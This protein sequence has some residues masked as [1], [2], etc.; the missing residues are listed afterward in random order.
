MLLLYVY[1]VNI[2]KASLRL[3]H[4]SLNCGKDKESSVPPGSQLRP[5]CRTRRG[6]RHGRAFLLGNG[7]HCDPT[8]S[9]GMKEVRGVRVLWFRLLT[10]LV[11]VMLSS[12]W[13]LSL[14]EE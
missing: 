12:Y 7:F 3:L 8:R 9:L 14:T 11:Q 6:G 5:L 1:I 2:F 4:F 10:D 13:P